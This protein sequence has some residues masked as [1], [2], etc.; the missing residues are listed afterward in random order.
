MESAWHFPTRLG[1][2][3]YRATVRGATPVPSRLTRGPRREGFGMRSWTGPI[4]LPE[5]R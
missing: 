5:G 2:H 4:A 3:A 1:A